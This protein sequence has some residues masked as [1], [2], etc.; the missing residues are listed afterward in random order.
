MTKQRDATWGRHDSWNDL[1][2]SAFYSPNSRGRLVYLD[3]DHDRI[4]SLA[5]SLSPVPDDP[6]TDFVASI[7][8]TLELARPRQ[9]IFSPH[10]NRVSL[11]REG[12]RTGP[13]PCVALLSLFVLAAEG[14][15]ADS[16]YS[17][18]N[19]YARLHELVSPTK[20]VAKDKLGRDFR[21]ESPI[22]WGVLNQWLEDRDGGL[23]LPTAFAF[24]RR[25]FVGIPISQALVREADR[26][27]LAECF[28]Q[29][30]LRP[31]QR[32]ATADMERILTDWIPYARV[33][34]SLQ[35]LWA[36]PEVR[37]RI[38]E[39]ACLELEAWDGRNALDAPTEVNE[40][41]LVV[42]LS[43]FEQPTRR[44]A[45]A[46]V[47]REQQ[48]LPLGKYEAND[49][50]ECITERALGQ[51]TLSLVEAPFRGYAMLLGDRPL[52]LSLAL[53]S[54]LTLRGA[55]EP[56]RHLGRRWKAL[57][58]LRFDPE[59]RLYV[60]TKRAELAEKLLL[61]VHESQVAKVSEYLSKVAAPGY[62]VLD[63]RTAVGVPPG[64]KIFV[65]LRI[66]GFADASDELN[67]LV[68]AALSNIILEGGLELPR[69]NTWHSSMPP[70]VRTATFASGAFGIRLMC[71]QLVGGKQDEAANDLELTEFR[72]TA[73]YDLAEARP[74][75]GD[76][77]I[78]VEGKGKVGRAI[79][80]A[81]FRIRDAN[82]PRYVVEPALLRD[83]D[84][85]GPSWVV[86]S[87]LS[88]DSD[89]KM[90][91][92][93]LTSFQLPEPWLLVDSGKVP[94]HLSVESDTTMQFASDCL[95]NEAL[96]ESEAALPTCIE[97]GYHYWV[98]PPARNFPKRYER[99]LARCKDCGLERWFGG[100]PV[101]G[102]KGRTKIRPKVQRQAIAIANNEVPEPPLASAI[103][104]ALCYL[105]R[106]TFHSLLVLVQ[107]RL[108]KPWAAI[109]FARN[110]QALG[111]LELKVDSY[112]APTHWQVRPTT[113]V[114]SL[115][116]TYVVG[117]LSGKLLERLAEDAEALGA[118][119]TISEIEDAPPMVVFSVDDDELVQEIVD[120][121]ASA[122]RVDIRFESD[123]ALTIARA[124]PRCS[125]V[126]GCLPQYPF[127]SGECET[128]DLQLSQWR[129]VSFVAAPGIYRFRR[130][131]IIYGVVDRAGVASQ[132]MRLGDYRLVKHAGAIGS[133]AKLIAYEPS[134]LTLKVPV[135]AELP[136]IYERAAVMESGRL[137]IKMSDGV[138][139]YLGV[140]PEVAFRIWNAL[141][142]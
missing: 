100:R 97:R 49:S 34:A 122:L 65:H 90:P 112:G 61:I 109:E 130:N 81:S 94:A 140:R 95:L 56:G 31:G 98:F 129:K 87:A 125:S 17:S 29:Y 63:Q 10:V 120:S 36:K 12:P 6:V 11:W 84:I 66:A 88:D 59:T 38:S 21:A 37:V 141:S 68:P 48:G 58:V 116:G 136:G 80:T 119:L 52:N 44:F 115:N 79:A 4:A 18:S 104:D 23:G 32:I 60:E 133:G 20:D 67:A 13:P 9:R 92:I 26:Q 131:R 102:Q 3:V 139:E 70:K 51:K 78:L 74:P 55:E 15:R 75:P 138:V 76:Y 85:L 69:R 71:E 46:F 93:G 39:V 62:M 103:F 42:A 82:R 28:A 8:R 43:L 110:C 126:I 40:H 33:S 142:S 25:R 128:F 127:P 73:I 45:F 96:N 77:R 121:T 7:V 124:L 86:N 99:L 27:I 50:N 14:M 91:A 132:S 135:G 134:R 114:S 47:V 117:H 89:S 101:G 2:V 57:T 54:T 24:D 113:V 137:P 107:Q 5:G 1:I 123:P 111:H 106:G 41:E 83:P 108:D 53:A 72:E 35:H 30:G 105:Q 118:R 19:Y 16:Q 22:F 64:W